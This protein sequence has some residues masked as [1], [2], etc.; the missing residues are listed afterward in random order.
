MVLAL[1]QG[2]LGCC[3]ITLNYDFAL[4]TF[5]WVDLFLRLLRKDSTARSLTAYRPG[6]PLLFSHVAAPFAHLIVLQ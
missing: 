5:E 2:Y 1:R 4:F 3:G 6:V